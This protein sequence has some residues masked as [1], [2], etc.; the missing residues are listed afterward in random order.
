[1][2]QSFNL[3]GVLYFFRVLRNPSLAVPHISVPDI[4]YLNYKSLRAAGFKA[5]AFDKDNCLTA[6]YQDVIHD[7]FKHAWNNCL[8][9][10]GNENILVYSNSAGSA[11]DIDHKQAQRFE[12]SLGV[13]VLRHEHKKPAGGK[14]LLSHF[15]N[16]G[17][18][19]H[20]ILFVGDRV[21]TDVVFANLNGL[22]AVHTSKIIDTK[23]DNKMAVLVC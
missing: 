18:G 11:D 5:I 8:N 6:P 19:P 3:A 12:K 7:P 13:H 9:Q 23:G 14:S 17:F 16:R 22:F 4:R 2:V 10:F 1:M 15:G 21:L 20:E